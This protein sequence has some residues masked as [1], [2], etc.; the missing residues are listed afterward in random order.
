MGHRPISEITAPE[1]LISLKK[2]EALGNYETAKRLRAV[3]GRV[4]RYAISTAT[5]SND[6]TYALKG[7]L[8][9]PTVTHRAALT[10]W[11]AFAGLLR[12]IWQYEAQL[13]TDPP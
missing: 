9:S 7:S 8:V 6:P 1:I 12:A 2:I 5:A 4:F 10:N 11:D 3:V 13:K